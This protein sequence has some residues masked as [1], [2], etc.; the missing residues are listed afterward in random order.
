MYHFPRRKW[1]SGAQISS[2]EGVPGVGRQATRAS[3]PS[4]PEIVRDL[5]RTTSRPVV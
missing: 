5:R 3:A 1:T 4:S 2:L